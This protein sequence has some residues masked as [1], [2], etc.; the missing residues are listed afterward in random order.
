MT[1]N[2]ERQ[3]S[4][5]SSSANGK[6]SLNPFFQS[7]RLIVKLENARNAMGKN[8]ERLVYYQKVSEGKRR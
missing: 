1:L 7:L 6:R 4:I 3:L 8:R 2:R 5:P